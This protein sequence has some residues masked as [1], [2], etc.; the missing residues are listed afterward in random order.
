MIE[1]DE[2]VKLIE[3]MKTVR[4]T[5]D[6]CETMPFI[7]SL[8]EPDYCPEGY[9]VMAHC[10]GYVKR[11]DACASGRS[12]PWAD[13]LD[14]DKVRAFIETDPRCEDTFETRILEETL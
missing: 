13:K 2:V 4:P 8:R 11:C 3:R 10:A 14:V 7:A 1:R 12:Y 5:C 6:A 9:E